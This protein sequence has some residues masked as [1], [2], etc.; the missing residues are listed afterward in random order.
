MI[1]N[2]IERTVDPCEGCDGF[3]T[4]D[5]CG[6]KTDTDVLICF[7]CKEHCGTMCDECEDKKE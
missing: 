6:A 7:D 4:S 1:I 3:K 2:E 5:C